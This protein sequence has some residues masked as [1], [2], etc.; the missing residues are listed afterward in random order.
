MLRAS[1]TI[2]ALVLS[3]WNSAAAPHAAAHIRGAEYYERLQR[4]RQLTGVDNAQS[5]ELYEGLTEAYPD[6]VEVC[7]EFGNLLAQAIQ[8]RKAA[9]AYSQSISRGGK[10]NAYVSHQIARLYALAGE[11]S[12]ALEWLEKSLMVPM[13]VRPQIAE[14]EAFLALRNDDDFRRLGGLLPKRNFSREEGWNYDLD[15]LVSEIR[16]MH[17]T[18][19]KSAI[20]KGLE[21]E[22][23]GLRARIPQLS[24]ELMVPEIQRIV[25]RLGDGHSLVAKT[26]KRIPLSFYSFSDGLFVTDAPEECGCI[27]DRVLGFGPTSAPEA[28]RRIEPFLSVDNPMGY[29]RYAPVYLHFPDYLVAAGIIPSNT[30]V[31]VSLQAQGGSARQF[32]ARPVDS[33]DPH[34]KLFP[35]KTPVAGTVPRYLMHV[36]DLYW[37]EALDSG[38]TIYFQFN[39]VQDKP[40]EPVAQFAS[41]LRRAILVPD[42]RNL[43]IDVRHN[44]GGNLTLLPPLLRAIIA[45]EETHDKPGLYLITGRQTFS[46]AQVFTNA[47]DEYT[48]VI[49][50]GEPSSSRPNFVGEGSRTKLPY[51]G[52]LVTIS[53]RYHQTDDQDD[54]IWIAPKIPVELSSSDYFSN[55]DPVLDAVL[56]VISKPQI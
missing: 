35:S 1:A 48:D 31:A 55:R 11:K 49:V 51:S 22:I 39:Q 24:D 3:A 18:F 44:N 45:F 17:Y 28:M 36:D 12:L 56:R 4:A 9:E 43:I 41:R 50:A 52:L 47:L 46:A 40:D 5:A 14:D 2:L 54:R 20:S 10:F 23:K 25:A 53:A 13:E 7:L 16:R 42:V 33:S 15:F 6:D 8:Y 29:R 30:E 38:H 21:D 27:G 37:F 34:R 32:L 26:P 19:R